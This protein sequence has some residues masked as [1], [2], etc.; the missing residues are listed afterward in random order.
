MYEQADVQ[1]HIAYMYTQQAD[2]TFYMHH[3]SP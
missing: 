2:G 3:V 1:S